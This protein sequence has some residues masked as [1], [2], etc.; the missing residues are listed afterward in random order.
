M[1]LLHATVRAASP[2]GVRVVALHVHH[3]LSP[4]ADLWQEHV[5]ERCRRWAR[6]G[7]PV[8]FACERVAG[9]PAAGDSVEAWARA[10]R[11][12][13][14]GR[15]AREHGASLVL[16]AHHRR[17]Q[18]ETLLLQAL[19]GSGLTGLAAMPRRLE[20]DGIVFARPW[21]DRSPDELAR[22]VRARRIRHV[23]DESNADVRYD[24]N[25]LRLHVWPTVEAAFPQA[26]ATLAASAARLQEAQQA[27]AELAS[28]DLQLVAPDG[29]LHVQPWS[30]LSPARAANA[31]RA[32]L[33]RSLAI[34]PGAALVARLQAELPASRDGRWLVG[35][36][37]LCVHRGV[38]HAVRVAGRSTDAPREQTLCIV[39]P[40]SYPL[41]G[42]HGA[43]DV[44]PADEGGVTIETLRRVELLPRRGGERWQA[45]PGRPPRSLKKQYQAAGVPAWSRDAPLVYGR[46]S[47]LYVPGLG[48]DARARAAPG[49]PQ[50]LLRWRPDRSAD[51]DA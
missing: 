16:L 6:Q 47:L 21:L 27:L 17:D 12:A 40:G 5:A 22:Y 48:I 41:P 18:A 30:R 15:L 26:E 34:A 25:R 44:E 42:W 28:L 38:L 14:L 24:R 35:E 2:L 19:R 29:A 50:V 39:A 10:H 20:R 45:G 11:H 3:G 4:N 1:A 43:L 31:L 46:G 8:F 36:G 13:A 23:D 32:W 33:R 51:G 7:L 49:E 9:R 37:A